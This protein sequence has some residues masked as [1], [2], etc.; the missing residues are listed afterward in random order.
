MIL[1]NSEN[2]SNKHLKLADKNSTK[3]L[4]ISITRITHFSI[5][6]NKLT[7]DCANQ[8][9][10]KSGSVE[11]LEDIRSKLLVEVCAEYIPWVFHH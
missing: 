4:L 1:I 3:I 10:F 8:N 11:G 2:S 6:V 9:S 7:L 5:N